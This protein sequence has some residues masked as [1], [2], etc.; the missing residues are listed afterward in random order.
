MTEKTYTTEE[1]AAATQSW[2]AWSATNICFSEVDGVTKLLLGIRGQPAQSIPE[3]GQYCLIGGFNTVVPGPAMFEKAA[4]AHMKAQ[5][6]LDW[7]GHYLASD[8]LPCEYDMT[9]ITEP[10]KTALGPLDIKRVA[11]D[12]VVWIREDFVPEIQPQGKISGI[13]WVTK[14]EFEAL[15]DTGELSFPH[16]AQHMFDAFQ[17]AENSDYSIDCF[18]PEWAA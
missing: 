2:L 16:Q 5:L 12:R 9:E 14:E 11:F 7:E 8:F 4:N 6:G 13:Q 17:I 3:P 15:F 18:G 10:L 1:I